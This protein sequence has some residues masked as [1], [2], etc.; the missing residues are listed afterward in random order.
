MKKNDPIINIVEGKLN[1]L[2]ARINN[3]ENIVS[4]MKGSLNTLKWAFSLF[5]PII[6]S[7]L[8]YLVLK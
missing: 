1:S 7:L 5:I 4:E 2:E 3:L 6:I 8:V